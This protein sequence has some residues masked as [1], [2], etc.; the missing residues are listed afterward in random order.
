MENNNSIKRKQ[1]KRV[2]VNPK[3]EDLMKET[4]RDSI[5][6]LIEEM[7]TKAKASLKKK[8]K[9]EEDEGCSTHDDKIEEAKKDDSYLETDMNKRQKNNEKA[10]ADMKKTKAYRDMVKAASKHFEET[11][12]VEES[13]EERKELRKLAAQ[14]RSAEKK[15]EIEWRST[16]KPGEK[17]TGPKY[18]TTKLPKRDGADY[19]EKT[20]RSA[21]AIDKLTRGKTLHGMS[22]E[23][24]Q[25]S[26]RHY[27]RYQT[28]SGHY[29]DRDEPGEEDWRPDVKAHNASLKKKKVKLK[30]EDEKS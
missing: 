28:Y 21:H 29:K 13:S 11:E 8:E 15:H 17:K 30:K 4:Y 20:L 12:Y 6:G 7:K 22:E 9:G 25:V 19:A 18:S 23:S 1:F 27:G 16:S 3:T 2:V 24:E 26:E 14:E 5:K 10:I